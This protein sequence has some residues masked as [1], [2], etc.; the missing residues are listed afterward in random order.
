MTLAF[1]NISSAGL[2]EEAKVPFTDH[3]FLE[4][5]LDPWCPRK[6][7]LRHFMHLVCVGLSKNPYLTVEQ[8]RE[9]IQ[10]YKDYFEEKKD[11]LSRMTI[12]Q[13]TPSINGIAEK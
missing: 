8:K 10:W 7:P 12:Q 6:G 2:D 9:H 5:Y 11:V 4:D 1:S 3:V 13:E